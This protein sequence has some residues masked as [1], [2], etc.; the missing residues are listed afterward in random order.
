MFPEDFNYTSPVVLTFGVTDIPA[1]TNGTSRCFNITIIKDDIYEEDQNFTIY[2]YDVIP[3][4]AI[5]I[6]Q[7]NLTK[8]IQDNEGYN[9]IQC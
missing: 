5:N 2:I 1:V 8:I 3:S 9:Y 4:A 7:N 6:I